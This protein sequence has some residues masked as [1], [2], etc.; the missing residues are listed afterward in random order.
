[1][2]KL[3]YTL[4]L[5][6]AFV[7]PLKAQWQQVGNTLQ[8][9]ADGKSYRFNLGSPGFAYWYTKAQI[10]SLSAMYGTLYI[11]NGT[12]AQVADFNITGNGVIGGALNVTGPLFVTAN[13]QFIN[14][15]L[16]FGNHTVSGFIKAPS[17]DVTTANGGSIQYSHTTGVTDWNLTSTHTL[18][19]SGSVSD[20]NIYGGG[21]DPFTIWTNTSKR[22]AIDGSGN[23]FL[24]S[25]SSGT[26][27]NVL[28]YDTVT[29]KLTY[30]A[31]ATGGV[32]SVSNS[33]GTITFSPTSGAVV[34]SVNTA[35]SFT[36]ANIHGFSNGWTS[37]ANVELK[38]ASSIL[39]DNS[40]NTITTTLSVNP[41]VGA[42]NSVLL[43]AGSGT[44]ALLTSP[45]FTGTPTA[46]TATVGT[47]TT[48]IATTAFVL[49]NAGG[50]PGGSNTQIQYNNSGSF[51]G[52]S[53]F[54][55]VPGLLTLSSSLTSTPRGIL[56]IQTSSD[57]LGSRITMQK[58]RGGGVITTGDVLGS[59]TASGHDG[60]N[61]V[62]A[63]KVL[64]TSVGAIGTGIVPATMQ[65]QTANTSGTLTTAVTIDQSQNTTITKPI[66][67]TSSTVGYVWTATNTAGAGNWAAAA[68]P[69]SFSY[70]EI[71]S[72]TINGTNVT[73][74]LAH[75]PTSGTVRLFK[76][77]Q[78]LTPTTDYTVS[79]GVVT[80]VVAPTTFPTTDVLLSNYNY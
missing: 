48:Q 62:D 26:T 76:N 51:G 22:L 63:A 24:N 66:L 15:L 11:K 25:L 14:D 52:N 33:D 58:S 55:F 35:H 29:G 12:L 61:Y 72:G 31:P 78:L 60:T 53:G 8:R 32:T 20:M 69:V 64:V 16:V 6:T 9:T 77:G 1:M 73:F 44:L 68:S 59:W 30:G 65:L 28:Y 57:A 70:N 21:S 23:F 7:S 2:K 40:L 18:T 67:T 36:W 47:N 13:S 74:T 45:A 46:P 39:F 54:T 27:S 34:G 17:Y 75:T 56:A 79:S 42:P 41:S 50:V 49:A 71:P 5:I 4:L 3:I 37:S 10:D 38:G 43:P 19:G 80:M